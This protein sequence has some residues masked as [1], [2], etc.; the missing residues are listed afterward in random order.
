MTGAEGVRLS[1]ALGRLFRE[2]RPDQVATIEQYLA[3]V[4]RGHHRSA[5][6]QQNLEDRNRE[7]EAALQGALRAA[8]YYYP[9]V[10]KGA[11]QRKAR[12]AGVATARLKRSAKAKRQR[13]TLRKRIL[14]LKR[15]E[16]LSINAIARR[17]GVGKN[18]IR[19]ALAEVNA[20]PAASKLHSTKA[21][22]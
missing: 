20:R 2:L 15:L 19:Q 10:A 6:R 16:D 17:L 11:D 3:F 14:Q 9:A 12:R 21:A 7:L 18:R 1:R 8:R 22:A 4:A 13:A 5:R